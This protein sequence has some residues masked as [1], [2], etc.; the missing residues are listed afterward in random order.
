MLF[1]G[2]QAAL[3]FI[4]TPFFGLTLLYRFLNLL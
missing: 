1:R 3:E 2:G 4:A